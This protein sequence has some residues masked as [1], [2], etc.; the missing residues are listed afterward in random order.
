MLTNMLKTKTN[1]LTKLTKNHIQ[2]K[3]IKVRQT[4]P[5][6]L[7]N[8]IKK[9]MRKR[10]RLYDKYKSRNSIHDF[11]SYKQTRNKITEAIRKAKELETEKCD[12]KAKT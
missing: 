1:Q 4:D 2:N 8:N 9:L 5:P 6:W 10:K 12:A 3:L 11:E 7:C